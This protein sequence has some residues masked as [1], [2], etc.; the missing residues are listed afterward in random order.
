MHST[1]LGSAWSNLSFVAAADLIL[2]PYLF[3]SGQLII[4]RSEISANG[5]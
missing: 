5:S 3:M 2:S 1:V 4:S